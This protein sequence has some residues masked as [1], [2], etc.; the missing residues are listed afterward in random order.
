MLNAQLFREIDFIFIGQ[1]PRKEKVNTFEIEIET[2]REEILKEFRPELVIDFAFLT[3][4]FARLWGDEHYNSMNREVSARLM[5]IAKCDSVKCILSASSGAAVQK[6]TNQFSSSKPDYYGI[7]KKA[8]EAELQEI[9]QWRGINTIVC[10]AWSVTGGFVRQPEMYAFSDFVQSVRTTNAITIESSHPVLR[11]FC[12]VEDFLALSLAQA[13]EK[14]FTVVESGGPLLEVRELAKVIVEQIGNESTTIHAPVQDSTKEDRYFS[15]GQVWL[16]IL[17]R[18]SFHP[19]SLDEQI[20]NVSQAIKS[21]L[22]IP[23]IP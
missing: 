1:T 5:R 23:K 16:N 17:E 9:S 12:S 22:E 20:S 14:G 21:R 3:K 10:R 15:D 19:L 2:W 6:R 8:N 18:H 13:E 7:Q 11:R 4:E